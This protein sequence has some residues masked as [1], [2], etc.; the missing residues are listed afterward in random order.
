MNWYLLEK[1][2]HLPQEAI[3]KFRHLFEEGNTRPVE[4]V[5]D[6]TV[7]RDQKQK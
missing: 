3:E 7:Y 6:R 5:G 4:P 2:A 1:Q